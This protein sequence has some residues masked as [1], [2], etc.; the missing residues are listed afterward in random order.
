MQVSTF[1]KEAIDEVGLYCNLEHRPDVA[2]V[3]ITGEA[4]VSFEASLD[5]SFFNVFNQ[6]CVQSNGERFTQRGVLQQFLS[7][8]RGKIVFLLLAVYKFALS[9]LYLLMPL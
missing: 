4:L 3:F 6:S 8:G 5:A 1:V 7:A 9:M 2:D